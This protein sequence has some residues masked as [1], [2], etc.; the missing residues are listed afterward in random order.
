MSLLA[1]GNEENEMSKY[2]RER[3]QT[4]RRMRG[5]RLTLVP[6]P[7]LPGHGVQ[8]DERYHVL[9]IDQTLIP[10][11][12]TEFRVLTLL[13]TK[14]EQRVSSQQLIAQFEEEGEQDTLLARAAREKLSRL[15][16]SLRP[17]IWT[18]GL[19]IV[20]LTGYGYML[21]SHDPPHDGTEASR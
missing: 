8:W 6:G 3:E 9:Y 7:S 13:L 11:T 4:Y 5:M 1:R 14:H 20:S 10:C 12:P 21:F 19:D 17:K 15:I 18:C 2:D 16:S